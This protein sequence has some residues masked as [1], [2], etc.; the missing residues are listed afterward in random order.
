MILDRDWSLEVNSTALRLFSD[1]CDCTG[2]IQMNKHYGAASCISDLIALHRNAHHC[3]VT[4][5]TVHSPLRVHRTLAD[6][7]SMSHF[8]TVSASTCLPLAF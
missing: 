1:D 3:D 8:L 7:Q 5:S 6:E 2:I 4:V